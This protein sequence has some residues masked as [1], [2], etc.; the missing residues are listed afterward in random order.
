MAVESIGR[1]NLARSDDGVAIVEMADHEGRNALS[2]SFVADLLAVIERALQ[3]ADLK[4]VVLTGLPEVFCAGASREALE[5]V[6]SG[7][8]VPSDLELGRVLLDVRVPVIAAMEGHAIGGGLALGL[9]AD[10]TLVARESRYGCSFMNLGFTP[11]MGVTRLL[12]LVLPSAV[13]HEM[14]YA[15]EPLKG[16]HFE[17]VGGFNHV[18]P[19]ARVRSRALDV[20][21]RIAEKPA[22]ALTSLKRVLAAPKRQ[23]FEASRADEALLHAITLSQPDIARR[24]EDQYVG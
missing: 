13:A 19:R 12:P 9:Y 21:A 7:R 17:V 1:V 5:E 2:P 18:L 22:V 3:W 10:V 14:M 16:S 20:A 8:V 4:V 6:A 11:G 15:G 23:A 24:I